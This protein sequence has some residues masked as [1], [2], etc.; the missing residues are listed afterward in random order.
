MYAYFLQHYTILL[1]KQLILSY[2]YNLLNHSNKFI[3]EI[4]F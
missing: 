2:L 4:I 3:A 1:T